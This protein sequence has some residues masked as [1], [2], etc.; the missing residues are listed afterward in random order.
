MNLKEK[1]NFNTIPDEDV[2]FRYNKCSELH[3]GFNRHLAFFRYFGPLLHPYSI[4]RRRTEDQK[5]NCGLF[6]RKFALLLAGF[7]LSAQVGME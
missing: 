3:S 2:R 6:M 5:L 1:E 7:L 4:R